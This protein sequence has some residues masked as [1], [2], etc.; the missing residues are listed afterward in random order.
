RADGVEDDVRARTGLLLDPYFSATKLAW[1]LDNVDGALALAAS[2]QI[3]AGTIDCWIIWRLT[4]GRVHA[5]D[6]TN[7]SRTM[8]YNIHD[9]CWDPWLLDLFDVPETILPEVRDCTAD[10][11]HVDPALFGVGLPITGVAGDQHAAT[12]GQACFAPGMIKSTY[13]TGAFLVLNTG[14]TPVTSESGLLTTLAYRIGGTSTYALEGSI[15]SAGSAVQWLRDGLGVIATASE[16]ESHAARLA[17][18]K[19][20]YLVPAFTGLGAP[21]WDAEARGLITGIGR[22]TGPSELARAAL[23]SVAYQTRDL[24]DSMFRDLGEAAPR[25][26]QRVLRADGGMIANRWLMQFVAD[27]AGLPVE[28]PQ[29]PE[30]TALGAAFLAGLGAGLIPDL[31][32]VGAR[33]RCAARY[34][35]AMDEDARQTLY[36]G[37]QQALNRTLWSA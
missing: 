3:L 14:D 36:A 6:A 2:G 13:G 25:P 9:G 26:D 37:W 33:W 8:L 22:D 4:G 11:G 30:T 5:T 21:H 34:E 32:A 16:T 24:I 10:F 31:D 7:A 28:A 18:N 17:H 29:A 35:P 20:V 19:G 1:L 23:E 27:M 15:F 12:V